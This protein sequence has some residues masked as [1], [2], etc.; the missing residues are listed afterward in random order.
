MDWARIPPLAS[1][2]AFEAAAR[3]L[4]YSAAGREL[5]VSHAA[6]AQQVRG[7]EGWLGFKLARRAG[8]GIELTAE[9]IYLAEHLVRGFGEIADGLR[10][11]NDT[12]AS[13]PVHVTMTPSF[14]MN[15]FLPRMQLFRVAHPDIDM[16]VNPTTETIDFATADC[17]VA[18]R[19]GHGEWSGLESELLLPSNFAIVAAPDLVADNWTGQ[20]ED[21]ARLPWLQELGTREVRHWLA[22]QGIEMPDTAHVTDLPGYMMLTALRSGQGIAATARVFVEDDIETGRVMVLFEGERVPSGGYHLV[23]RKGVQRDAVRD[24]LNWI[25]AVAR[26]ERRDAVASRTTG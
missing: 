13:R 8:R 21:L 5:N 7:L 12:E 22:S 23:W 24:F 16:V 17:D 4:N 9:G 3:N 14:S 10:K 11:L 19:Y 15:W 26:E 18:I 25:R 2:R 6:V 1:L 20:L